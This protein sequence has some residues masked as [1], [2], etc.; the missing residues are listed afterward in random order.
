[1]TGFTATSSPEKDSRVFMRLLRQ[2]INQAASTPSAGNQ[3]LSTTKKRKLEQ[4][5]KE[6][7][8]PK[9]K[10][11]P[12]LAMLLMAWAMHLC[13]FGTRSKKDIAFSTVDKYVCMVARALLNTMTNIDFLSLGADA[14]E[15]YYLEIL[16]SQ[17]EHRREDVAGRLYEFHCFYLKLTQLRS[18]LGA[19]FSD[20]QI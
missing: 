19:R 18:P 10:S 7:V 15:N 20:Y 3:K 5:I 16:E 9:Q 6:D 12:Q 2:L 17:P 14:Y 8:I 1:M 13:K 4:L 11:M